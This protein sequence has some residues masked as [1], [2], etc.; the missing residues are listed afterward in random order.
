MQQC[1]L[2][3]HPAGQEVTIMTEYEIQ[4]NSRRCAITGRELRSGEPY[5]TALLEADGQFVRQDYSKEAW[6]GPPQGAFSFWSG[7]VPDA[8]QS[9]K[10]RIDDNLLLECFERLEGQTEPGRI[11][12]RY[13]VALLLMR[14]KRLKFEESTTDGE[15]EVLVL[16]SV[17]AGAKHEVVN[18]GMTEDEMTAVQEEVFKVLG[19]Q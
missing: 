15:H 19:W 9:H 7:H 3:G 6:N 14:R 4:P 11:S 12:F 18:P 17:G 13:V 2:L 10:P 16:R 8:A 1:H 5:Y